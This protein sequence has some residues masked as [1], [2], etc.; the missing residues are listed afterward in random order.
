MLAYNKRV[1]FLYAEQQI[2]ERGG[3]AHDLVRGAEALK[4]LFLRKKREQGLN[5]ALAKGKNLVFVYENAGKRA[6][7][8]RFFCFY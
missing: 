4:A 5:P 3:F 6:F 2:K 8:K 7:F 1:Q